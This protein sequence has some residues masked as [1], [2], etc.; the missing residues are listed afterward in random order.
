MDRAPP[1]SC[2]PAR[3]GFGTFVLLN[4]SPSTADQDFSLND[5]TFD[6]TAGSTPGWQGVAV[7]TSSGAGSHAA[8]ALS[9]TR[10]TAKNI[11]SGNLQGPA[12]RDFV[13]QPAGSVTVTDSTFS[14]NSSLTGSSNGGGAIFIRGTDG[15]VT[16]S[17][18]TFTGNSAISGGAI[19]VD[20]TGGGVPSVSIA[21]STFTNN[22]ATGI[23]A[24]SASDGNGGAI[25]ANLLG[26]LAISGSTF[27]GNSAVANGGAVAIDALQNAATQV[28]ITSSS[29][30]NNRAVFGGGG[31][32]SATSVGDISVTGSTFS[33]NSL[34]TD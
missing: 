7:S 24:D 23:G 11:S 3:G 16:V 27:S 31:F 14:N 12:L 5:V 15:Q 18:T 13:M 2:S 6:G 29:F 19:F 4:V 32:W 25:A 9:L 22:S 28:T 21:S 20:G 17:G 34:P 33:A 30:L 1:A 26:S 8:R 10:V